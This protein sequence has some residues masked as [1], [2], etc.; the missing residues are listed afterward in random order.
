MTWSIVCEWGNWIDWRHIDPVVFGHYHMPFRN[1]GPT[2]EVSL[3]LRNLIFW[4]SY[5]QLPVVD[6]GWRFLWTSIVPW[7]SNTC[8]F[9]ESVF[10]GVCTLF[11]CTL[12]SLWYCHKYSLFILSHCNLINGLLKRMEF[13]YLVLTP[14]EKGIGRTVYH[15]CYGLGW[16][17]PAGVSARRFWMSFWGDVGL[18]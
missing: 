18:L 1:F 13:F 14:E 6:R 7:V 5:V 2:I 8:S 11:V 4:I 9:Q 17:M 12:F 16:K 10:F 15:L 3:A